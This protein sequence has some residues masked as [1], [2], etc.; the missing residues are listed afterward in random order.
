MPDAG[1]RGDSECDQRRAED[2][3]EDGQQ[4]RASRSPACYLKGKATLRRCNSILQKGNEYSI[5]NY[6]LPGH[7][8]VCL[9]Y[10]ALPPLGRRVCAVMAVPERSGIT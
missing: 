10:Y 1:Q 6:D 5:G 2:E 3:A 4:N 8:P 7:L 9:V